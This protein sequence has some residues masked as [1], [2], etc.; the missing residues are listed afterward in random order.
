MRFRPCQT[1]FSLPM[2]PQNIRLANPKCGEPAGESVE[3]TEVEALIDYREDIIFG[4]DQK[5]VSIHVDLVSGVRRK[6]DAVSFFDLHARPI[7][8]MQ[9]SAVSNAQDFALLRLL[10]R[11]IRQHDTAGSSLFGLEA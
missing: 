7:P 9:N 10:F 1:S 3:K 6:N 8:R 4:Q 5:R 2:L 11:R